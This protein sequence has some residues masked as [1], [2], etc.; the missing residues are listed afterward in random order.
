MEIILVTLLGLAIFLIWFVFARFD[1]FIDKDMLHLK[2]YI[3][4]FIRVA[5][6][7]IRL[8]SIVEVRPYRPGDLWWSLIIGNMLLLH[9]Q[10]VVIQLRKYLYGRNPI[11]TKKVIFTP[12][13]RADYIEKIKVSQGTATNR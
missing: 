9:E 5:S 11:V 3:F 1:Y 4:G 7:K 12:K 2:W 13:N 6:I 10:G 8:G